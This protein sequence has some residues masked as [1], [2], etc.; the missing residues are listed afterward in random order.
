MKNLEILILFFI[1]LLVSVKVGELT[2]E[3]NRLEH[4]IECLEN[5]TIAENK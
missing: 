1:L 4:Q 5:A 3:V 2:E